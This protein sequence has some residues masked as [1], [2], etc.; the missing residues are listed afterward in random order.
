MSRLALWSSVFRSLQGHGRPSSSGLALFACVIVTLASLGGACLLSQGFA[1]AAGQ[2]PPLSQH[3]QHGRTAARAHGASEC[4]ENEEGERKRAS[5]SGSGRATG[6]VVCGLVVW[7]DLC[8]S[9][10]ISPLCD[11]PSRHILQNHSVAAA[12]LRKAQHCT[13]CTLLPFRS[14]SHS[15]SYIL[16]AA[17]AAP[18]G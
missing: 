4:E 1:P 8:A 9:F 5:A 12:V 16:K 2:H 15:S 13:T 18:E 11:A 3:N 17:Y 6:T 10:L 14:H 7:R